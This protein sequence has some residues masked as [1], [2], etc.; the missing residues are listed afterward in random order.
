MKTK[1]RFNMT[2][3][4]K[5]EILEPNNPIDH[6]K[7]AIKEYINGESFFTK[8]EDLKNGIFRELDFWDEHHTY[9]SDEIEAA[10]QYFN[11]FLGKQGKLLQEYRVPGRQQDDEVR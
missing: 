7:F 3:N 6:V 9:F 2:N 5:V 11:E 8:P 10:R 1:G 4:F